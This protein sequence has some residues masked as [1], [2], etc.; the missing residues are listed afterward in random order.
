MKKICITGANGFIGKSLCSNL[1]SHS[2]HVK[3]IVRNIYS[4]PKIKNLEY[5]SIGDIRSNINWEN[6]FY[7]SDCIIHCAGISRSINKN[8][9]QNNLRSI[10]V[11]STRR[12]AEDA[13]K[14]GV[15]RFIFLSSIKVNGESNTNSNKDKIISISDK[16]NP[17]DIYARSKFE[18]ENILLEISAKT[19]MEIVILRLPIVYGNG[20]KGNLAKLIKLI[21]FGIPLPFSMV[22]NQ[23][24]MI[25]IDNLVD[26]ISICINHVSAAGQIFFISVD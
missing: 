2:K 1:S 23:R 8:D 21:K 17:Q 15:K 6:H 10:N 26:V 22:K 16:P 7:E 13:A 11:E 14:A 4:E 19:N 12:I 5:V 20:V 25:G 24:S 9:G 18:A 3:G